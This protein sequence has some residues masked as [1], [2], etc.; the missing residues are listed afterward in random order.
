MSVTEYVAVFTKKMKLVSYLLPTKSSKV[1][2]FANGL[3]AD[4]GLMVK[5]ATTLEVTIQV[6][7]SLEGMIK[8]RTTTQAK[9]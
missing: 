9:V 5:L 4:F 1:K 8:E 6:A 2:S 7:L 3:P